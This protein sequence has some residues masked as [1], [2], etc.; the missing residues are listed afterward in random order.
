MHCLSAFLT[1]E[2]KHH[3][4][5]DG[6]EV[7]L[8]VHPE[9]DSITHNIPLCKRAHDLYATQTYVIQWIVNDY[10]RQQEQ[11]LLNIEDD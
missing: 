5:S 9:M 2:P 10:F 11:K 4:E 6:D 1:N 8:A 3:I 7:H